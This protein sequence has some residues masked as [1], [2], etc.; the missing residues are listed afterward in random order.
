MEAIQFLPYGYFSGHYSD[1]SLLGLGLTRAGNTA[2]GRQSQGSSK[3]EKSDGSSPQS[4]SWEHES[5][6]A[7]ALR[8]QLPRRG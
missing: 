2:D 8:F 1:S 5:L 4:G 7:C 3:N 6:L